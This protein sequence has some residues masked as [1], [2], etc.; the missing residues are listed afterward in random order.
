MVTA[1]HCVV[2]RLLGGGYESYFAG[3]CVRDALLGRE[4]REVDIATAAP[5][6]EVERLFSGRTVGVGRSFGVMVVLQD[7]FSF[8]VATFRSDG[9]YRDGRRPESVGGA[10]AEGDAQRRDFTVNG[11]FYDTESG[12]VV[13]YV[14]GVVDLERGVIRAIGDAAERFSEDR[15]RMM[16]GVRFASVLDFELEAGC[17]E[18]IRAQAGELEVVSRERIGVEFV[19]LLCESPRASVGMELLL[20][21]GLLEVFLP[22]VVRLKG[23]PQPPQYHPEGDVWVHTMLML[24]AMEAPR[25]VVLALAVLLHD[26]GKPGCMIG[27]EETESI[28]FPCH[29][30]EGAR[31]A[32]GILRRLRQ[33]AAVVGEVVELV[34]GHMRYISAM[35][36]R[37][38]KLRRL[39]GME[40]FER[41]LELIRLDCAHSNGDFTIWNFLR[42][43]YAEFV[44]E[45][46]LPPPLVM[47]RDLIGWGVEPGREM[48]VLL[49]ELY[50]AQL[51]GEVGSMAEAEEWYRK[52]VSCS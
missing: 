31:M 7:G 4:I 33:P 50:D 9:K 29:A 21:S 43:R 35:E 52:R 20:E 25:D 15:L 37:P 18:A 30:D 17:F 47:G 40:S 11:L 42:E 45:P 6:D 10:T 34:G 22:E 41:M 28:R 2:E 44:S 8:D 14:G 38:A 26:I 24:D 48:G 39:M 23:T 16:R 12:G 36:M 5:S 46:V 3:G 49:G 19:R 1:A 51:E 13:D 32:G 27:G